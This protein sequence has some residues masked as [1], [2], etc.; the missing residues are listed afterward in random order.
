MTSLGV[1]AHVHAWPSTATSGVSEVARVFSNQSPSSSRLQA[2][3]LQLESANKVTPIIKAHCLD[4]HSG[5]SAEAGVDLTQFA[6]IDDVRA[7][8]RQFETMFKLVRAGAMP[9]ADYSTLSTEERSTLTVWL[10]QALDAVASEAAPDT[11]RPTLRR[12]NRVE[13]NNTIRDLLGVDFSPAEDFPSDEVGY[14]FDNVGDV[15]SVSPLHLE[16][17]LDAAE[18]IATAAI[19]IDACVPF[20]REFS[21]TEFVSDSPGGSVDR[22]GSFHLSQRGEVRVKVN[23]P[24]AA[25]YV[26]RVEASADQAGD[27]LA[28]MEVSA[29]GKSLRIIEVED[30]RRV[31]EYSLR[32]EFPKGHERLTVAFINDYYKPEAKRRRDRNL[33]VRSIS[34]KRVGKLSTKE[35]PEFHQQL[36]RQL[37]QKF[38][39]ATGR[40]LVKDGISLEDMAEKVLRPFME[41]A[42]RRPVDEREIE[43]YVPFTTRAVA[44]G[45]TFERGIQQALTAVLVS[46]HFLFHIEG[47]AGTDSASTD[48]ASYALASR[49]SYFLWSSMPDQE[50]WELAATRDL[51]KPEVLSKQ[52]KRMLQDP[53]SAALVKNFAGQWLNLRRLDEIAP[54]DESIPGLDEELKHAMRTETE[55]FFTWALEEDWPALDLLDARVTFVNQRLAEHYGIPGI[56]G[57]AFQQVDLSQTLRLGLL[58]QASILTI[59]SNP[60][61][62]SPVKRGK[63]VL[64]NILGDAPPNPPAN[65]PALEEVSQANPDLP[66]REQLAIHRQNATCNSCHQLMDEIGFGFEEFGPLGKLR[67]NDDLGRVVDPA[68]KLP[69]GETYRGAAELI[70]L[71]KVQRS[72]NFVR[73]LTEKLLTYALGR[74]VTRRDRATIDTIVANAAQDEHRLVRI[75]TE[76]VQSPPFTQSGSLVGAN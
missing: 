15:L 28:K 46:P 63:W 19:D 33:Q 57:D 17:Y 66:L 39:A 44:Q 12:L 30:H 71:L 69:T 9:P 40:I 51:E 10:D 58:S 72:E 25:E 7:K 37:P 56:K 20:E 74:G 48:L 27:E 34:I 5:E 38:D 50:L 36:I 60:T 52:V 49:L 18:R 13:Y 45:Q 3:R 64:E 22:S 62:T 2:K 53:K 75:I 65:V 24:V 76:I 47:Q 59:T 73:C 23:L 6:S 43:R 29:G 21:A 42:F 1:L 35:L 26:I 11:N 55:L 16:R 41:R 32:A 14:G 54:T 70:A 31:K 68:G 67:S 8:P 61:R 4:C